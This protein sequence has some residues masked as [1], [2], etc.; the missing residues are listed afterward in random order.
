MNHEILQF[1]HSLSFDEIPENRKKELQ[2][3]IDHLSKKMRDSSLINLNF[4]CTHNSRRSHFAQVWA[5]TLANYLEIGQIT[6]YSGGTEATAVY[7]SVLTTLKNTGFDMSEIAAG[8]NP[9]YAVKFAADQPPLII[10]SKEFDHPFNPNSFTAIM[11]C[12]D[13]DENCPFIPSAENRLKMTFED[14]KVSDGT[15]A[16]KAIYQERS[17]QIATEIKYVFQQAKDKNS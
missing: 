4:I 9:V 6:C 15:N 17:R 12:D 1:I 2:F 14:P 13:A 3:L 16:E 5:Q 10:F 11:T 7:Q 8:Q